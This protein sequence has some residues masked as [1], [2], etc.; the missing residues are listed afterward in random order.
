MLRLWS[1]QRTAAGRYVAHLLK[2]TELVVLDNLLQAEL[3][4]LEDCAQLILVRLLELSVLQ[5]ITQVSVC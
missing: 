4:V 2:G 1:T 5:Q 3:Q